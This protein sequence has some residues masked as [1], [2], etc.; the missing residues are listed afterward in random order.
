MAELFIT[1]T[2]GQTQR[3]S[4]T[5]P[6]I[7]GRDP[8]CDVPLEDLGTSRRHAR[9]FHEGDGYVVED[10]G[11]KN[12]TLLNGVPCRTGRLRDGD[13]MMV[14][15][16]RVTF[17][18]E[19][20]PR[21]STTSVIVAEEPPSKETTHYSHKGKELV[22]PQRRLQLIYELSDRLTRL[23]NRDEL[24]EE[25]MSICFETLNLER[26]AIAVRKRDGR[27]VEWP[28]VRN[29]RG[30]GGELMVSR[31]VLGRALDHGERAIINNTEQGPFDPTVSM[32]QHGIL[33][34]LCVPLMH[35]D[36]VLGVIYGDR[37]TSGAVYSE[38]DVDFLAG[39]ARQASIG[40]I[41]TR[42][43]AEQ[44][45]MLA[46]ER[47]IT[48]ARQIQQRLFP[49][50]LPDRPE[51]QVA[52]RNDPG[53][54][55]SGDYYDVIELGEGQV[56]FVIA[57]VTGEGI[58]AALLM[59]N[60]QAAVRLTM[61]PGCAPAELLGRWNRLIYENTEASKFVTCLTGVIDIPHRR[62]TL[63][64]AGHHPLIALRSHTGECNEIPCDPNFPL[65]VIEDVEY[66]STTMELSMA[67]R[68]LFCFTDGVIEAM[69]VDNKQFTQQR[70]LD[71]LCDSGDVPP[72]RL[73]V[74][75]RK[76]IS[77]FTGEATQSDDITMLA[78]RIV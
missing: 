17:R 21:E 3:V 9:V 63:A 24:L 61:H 32:V 65:G 6:V 31:T 39:L 56:G 55:V 12:G 15:S 18:D 53:R 70:M 71:A 5:G 59:S 77:A 2:D 11:S 66:D 33:S 23:R 67:A 54:H 74:N 25:V 8:T 48:V 28:V 69:D 26:G 68:T 41:N 40:L 45:E 29:L 34:A 42:L 75:V 36:E 72:D 1:A 49:S 22:L 7:L 19:S 51:L 64:N 37:T 58:A 73:I 52:A 62:L 30:A 16:V 35:N 44:Q 46:L 78:L 4:L 47:E 76:A 14:G 60:L 50:K 38:E 13:E 10:L 20:A 27:G 57:D 43:M